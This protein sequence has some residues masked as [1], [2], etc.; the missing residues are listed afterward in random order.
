VSALWKKKGFYVTA[1]TRNPEKL[2]ALSIAAQKC[3]ILKGNDE[4]ELTPLIANNAVLLM[5]IA[6]DSPEHYESAYLNTAQIL[7]HLALEMDMPRHL[8]YTS[9]TSVYGDHH[10]QWVDET[11]E[12]KASSAQAK[13]LIDAEKHYLSLQELGWH[14]C[15]LRLA[16]IYGPER[17][18]SR[19]V[20]QLEGHTLPGSGVHYTNM[21]HKADCASAIDYAHRHQLEGVYNLADEDHPTRKELYDAVSHKFRLPRVKWDSEH[22]PLHTG[23]KRVSNHKI[24]SEGFVFRHPIRI[25]D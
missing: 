12:L 16:E 10:G 19:R 22:T 14:V 18:L 15:I 8:I 13:I 20:K 23:N 21:I 11:S 4:E 3:M 5:T 24:K 7:R 2:D 9:S 25:L 6:A 1:T 17:E